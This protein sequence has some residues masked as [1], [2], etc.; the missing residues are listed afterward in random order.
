MIL[1]SYKN[2]EYSIALKIDRNNFHQIHLKIIIII[3]RKR[4]KKVVQVR[5]Q[6][7]RHIGNFAKH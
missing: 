6:R 5:D 1:I 2:V 7:K 4:R 3:R